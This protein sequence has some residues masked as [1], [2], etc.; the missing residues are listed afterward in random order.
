MLSK[1]AVRA[2][3]LLCLACY[4]YFGYAEP[5]ATTTTTTPNAV[6]ATLSHPPAPAKTSPGPLDPNFGTSE[7][8]LDLWTSG[9]C[10]PEEPAKTD[11]FDY[12]DKNS[13]HDEEYTSVHLR[14][15]NGGP[16]TCF[17]DNTFWINAYSDHDCTDKTDWFNQTK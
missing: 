16:A 8:A 10:T 3:A 17:E 12:K 4:P 14:C 7:F 5:V 13:Q 6:P 9:S 11:N 2:A 15:N 1:T